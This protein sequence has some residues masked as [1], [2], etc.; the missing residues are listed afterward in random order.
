[1]LV[2]E[3]DTEEQIFQLWFN[4]PHQPAQ[5]C[6]MSVAPIL[7]YIYHCLANSQ[8]KIYNYLMN[9]YSC[10]RQMREGGPGTSLVQRSPPGT[11]KTNMVH[12]LGVMAGKA[13]FYETVDATD[14]TGNFTANLERV[15]LLHLDEFKCA[16]QAQMNKLKHLVTG[17]AVR[18]RQMQVN[19]TQ[20]RKFFSTIIS[21]NMYMVLASDAGERR[22]VFL[23]MPAGLPGCKQYIGAICNV[24]YNSGEWVTEPGDPTYS[25]VAGPGVILLAHYFD[26]WRVDASVSLREIPHNA[27]LYEHQVASMDSVGRWW[28]HKL[29]AGSHVDWNALDDFSQKNVMLARHKVQLT[30]LRD[31]FINTW[32]GARWLNST[33]GL[34]EDAFTDIWFS[35]HEK[36][37]YRLQRVNW[38][39]IYQRL[40]APLTLVSPALMA[41]ARQYQGRFDFATKIDFFIALGDGTFADALQGSVFLS[42]RKYARA[43]FFYQLYNQDSWIRLVW[44]TQLYNLYVMQQVNSSRVDLVDSTKFI[45]RIREYSRDINTNRSLIPDRAE[46]HRVHATLVSRDQFSS[47]TTNLLQSPNTHRNNVNA[48]MNTQETTTRY[49][50]QLGSLHEHRQ[51]FFQQM[52]WDISLWDSVWDHELKDFTNPDDKKLGPPWLWFGDKSN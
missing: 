34:E 33:T 50:I 16:D 31:S 13:A 14:I 51:R 30:N 43:L 47:F 25:E 5:G 39:N 28:F 20:V 10:W 23:E 29:R 46:R 27:T 21:A 35:K 17:T 45:D 32:Q 18:Q 48:M 9:W 3:V 26:N 24:L 52:R 38:G 22:F 15:L 6:G 40:V 4:N 42:K 49:Y 1:M 8:E 37:D 19:V 12:A 2:E 41:L 7:H 44:Q 11:G 36:Y